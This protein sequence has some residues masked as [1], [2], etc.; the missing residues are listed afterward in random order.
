MNKKKQKAGAYV[1][2]RSLLL[3][4]KIFI[5]FFCT[6]VFAFTSE[7]SFSQKKVHIDKNQEVTVDGV[8]S[9]I[10]QQTDYRFIYPRHLFKNTPK[11]QLYKGEIAITELLKMSLQSSN[12]TYE[13]TEDETILV[14]EKDKNKI[15]LEEIQQIVTGIVTDSNGTPMTG[16]NVLIKGTTSGTM[17]DFDGK[18]SIEAKSGDTLLFSFV[19]METVSKVLGDQNSLDI[20]LTENLAS[21]DEIVVVGY[22]TQREKDITGA[23]TSVSA[24]NFNKGVQQSPQQLLQGKMPGVNIAQNSGKPGGSNTVLIRG[25]TSLTGSNDPLYVIDGIPIS[26]SSGTSQ[27]NISGNGTDFFDQEPV[28]PLMTLNP[29]D[30][31][32]ISVLKDASAT[33][34]YGSRG[35]NGVIVIT[36]KDGTAG[37]MNVSLDISHG[38]SVVS[39][40]L[41][42]LSADEYKTVINDLGLPLDDG[43]TSTNWQDKV[44]RTAQVQDYYLSLSGGSENSNYRAS[45]GYGDQEGVVIGSKLNRATARINLGQKMLDKKL[46]FDL[47]VNYG[48]TV[49]NAA[50]VSNT[51]GSEAGSSINYEAYVFNPTYSVYDENGNFNHILPYRVNPLSYPKQ[52]I[53]ERTTNRFLGN[54]TTDY[55]IID[56]LSVNVNLGYT[57]QTID[58][59]SY[60]S[61]EN[62][63]G[64]GLGGYANVQK[65]KSYNK[66]LETTLKFEKKFGEHS[67]N[68][69]AGYS[70]QYF[71]DEG[72]RNDANGFLSDE[73]KWYGLQAASN[74]RTVS[75]YKQSNTLISMYT[76]LNY[77]YAGKYLLTA[78][79]RRDGSSR[80]G[81]GNEWGVFPSGSIAWRISDEDFF[82]SNSI[83]D[84]KLRTS[85]GVTGNQEIG[86]L[87]S[88]T[89]L[90][91]STMGYIVGGQRITVVLPQQ[92][93]NPNLKW[94]Q[95]SQ[96]NVGVDFTLFK[97]RGYG[98]VDYYNKKT[99]DLLLRI[100]VP[101][102]TAVNTQLANVGSVR[103]RGIELSLG[104]YVIEKDDFQWRT[105]LIFSRNENEVLSLSNAQYQGDD[106]QVGPLRGQGLTSGTFAQ[107]I[108]PGFEVGTFYGREF[109]GIEDGVEQFDAEQK[110]IGSAQP[111]FT[112]GFSNNFTYK[113][114]DLSFNLRGSIGND[115]YNLTANNL[116]YLSNLPGRNVFQEA[117]DSGVTRDQPKQYSSRWIEDASFLRLD[118][119][120]LGYNF[121][122]ENIFFSNA[123]VY[124]TGQNLFV[125]T[126]YSGLDPEVNS[127]V[128]GGGIAPLGIDYL[129]YPKATTVTLGLNLTF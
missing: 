22:G 36:T 126:G 102:P 7:K 6:T 30:I 84:L 109:L 18:Y 124:L 29:S 93:A 75:S 119:L 27:A 39:N 101:T 21:L 127:E 63:L 42:V 125:I 4:M 92:Y 78:T 33:A 49:S 100:P 64:Q 123:R 98:T 10:K 115:V 107:L 34:I 103:N 3:I 69:L 12:L 1:L 5:I 76:R 37:K 67:I 99:T 20:S 121:N 85:Y 118:N 96:F 95:T 116:A 16:V 50:P 44:Y 105:N 43:G 114:F 122:T 66:L 31:E 9:I 81:S 38:V 60:L 79:V 53:D 52:V 35:A 11:V 57:N 23:V 13:V 24:K 90:G 65:L 94:E 58:R 86:N 104:A 25:G 77:D 32:S 87:N 112:F 56:P 97:G 113:A 71:V 111:D 61:K 26:T 14:K 46:S 106:I 82:K 117:I 91:A 110:K 2:K 41:E 89:T 129:A 73:F 108:R 70:Y 15:P 45:L 8:F 47:R 40:T 51:V 80:F 83:T 62:P 54:F 68:A 48:Q 120:S 72:L 128:S 19:G 74:I 59:N 28:N 17:T 55:K 88:I